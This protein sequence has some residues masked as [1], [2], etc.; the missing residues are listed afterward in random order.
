MSWVKEAREKANQIRAER[1][2]AGEAA[3]ELQIKE[4]EALLKQA[5]E[6]IKLYSPII[7]SLMD[8]LRIDRYPVAGPL[9]GMN[10][11]YDSHASNKPKALISEGYTL[12]ADHS[13]YK[14]YCRSWWPFSG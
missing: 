5:N 4:R 9:D 14:Y 12:H 3:R 13:G 6:I 11:D 7:E 8:D 10:L 1:E 2:A